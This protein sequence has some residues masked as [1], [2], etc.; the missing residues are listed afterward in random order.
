MILA[1]IIDKAVQAN[2]GADSEFSD[3]PNPSSEAI[4]GIPQCWQV[5]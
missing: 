1:L 4:G 3:V 2:Q 5:G